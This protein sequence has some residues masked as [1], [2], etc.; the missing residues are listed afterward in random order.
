MQEFLKKNNLLEKLEFLAV[1]D[2]AADI[3]FLEQQ[4]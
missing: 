1:L 4:V 2:M 3:T